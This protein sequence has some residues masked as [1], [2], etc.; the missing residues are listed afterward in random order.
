MDTV[1]TMVVLVDSYRKMLE[2]VRPVPVVDNY[3][4]VVERLRPVIAKARPVTSRARP[5]H[6]PLTLAS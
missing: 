1:G 2:N 3:T 5:V 6:S 4:Q